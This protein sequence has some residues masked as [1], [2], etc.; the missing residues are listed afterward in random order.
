M[1]AGFFEGT[2]LPEDGWWE[3]LWSDPAG[4]LRACGLCAGAVAVD[5]CAGN[6][7]FTLPMAHVAR[8]VVA[9]DIDEKLLEV[10]R[11]RFGEAGL[12]NCT[13]V[14]AD[15]YELAKVD[16][17]PVDF[18]FLANAFHGVPDQTRLS[19][20]VARVLAPRGRFVIV[21]WHKR[22][23]EETVVLGA[24]HGPR[25]ELRMSPDSVKAVVEPAGLSLV[26]VAELPPYHYAAI[27]A[28]LQA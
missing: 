16:T 27:F 15:A 22:P 11:R 12:T 5:L 19:R 23:R 4:V 8:Q 28:K 6:G 1:I 20:I 17:A 10:A 7:W 9:V 21:N 2:E 13:F 25:T 24:P 14:T 3:A 18:L 26:R